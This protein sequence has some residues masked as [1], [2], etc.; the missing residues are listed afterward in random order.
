MPD[1]I[2]LQQ[3]RYPI[4]SFEKPSSNDK[5]LLNTWIKDIEMLP[6]QLRQAVEGLTAEQLEL[7]YRPQ[8]WTIHQTINH[9]ADSHLNAFCRFKL[10]LTEKLPT[11]KPYE[12]Q[13][14]AELE[15]GK[16]APIEWSLIMLDVL[17][18]RWVMLLKSLSNEQFQRKFLH[19]ETKSENALWVVTGMYS[20]HGKHHTAHITQLRKR[21]GI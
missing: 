20:W 19:P 3:L 4:G 5:D 11:I 8:G 7:P 18:K 17:H 16:N 14:W 10:A 2:P 15:D 21:M 1:E 13:L 6:A 9:V 12:E